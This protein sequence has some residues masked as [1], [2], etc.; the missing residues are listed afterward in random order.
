M[1]N[2]RLSVKERLRCEVLSKVSKSCIS[3]QKASEL[4]CVS[5]RQVLRIWKRFREE[6]TAGLKH[7]LRDRASN[8]HFDVADRD[9]ILE[10]YRS[11]YGD[12][13]PTLAVEYLAKV[14]GEN[15]NLRD[16]PP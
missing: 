2:Q 11:K 13:G 1:S 8:H 7:G 3:L 10:L 4:L 16:G 14:D 6:G 12:F 9:R 5:Y 15:F